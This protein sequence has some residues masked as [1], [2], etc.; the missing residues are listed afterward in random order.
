MNSMAGLYPAKCASFVREKKKKEKK[1][2]AK[3]LS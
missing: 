3:L 1:E 2:M